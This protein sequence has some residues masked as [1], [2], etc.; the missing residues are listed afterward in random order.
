[1]KKTVDTLSKA[2]RN[3]GIEALRMVSMLMV[4]M[5]HIMGHGGILSAAVPGTLRYAAVWLW[6]TAAYCAVDCFA[7]ISGYVGAADRKGDI[8]PGFL[9]LWLRAAFYGLAVTAAFSLFYPDE[10]SVKD[11]IAA[12]LPVGHNQYWYLTAYFALMLFRP[13]LNHVL[14]TM[15]SQSLGRMAVGIFIGFSVFPL[16]VGQD[17]FRMGTGYHSLWFLCL[18]LLG[19]WMKRAELARRGRTGWCLLTYALLTL[20]TWGWK[21]G[22]EFAGQE[23][24]LVMSY[25]SP[26]VLLSGGALVLAFARMRLPRRLERTVLFLAPSAFS[27]Y[28]LHDQTLV[29]KYLIADRM[30][31]L[32]EGRTWRLLVLIPVAALTIYLLCTAVDLIRRLA[33]TPFERKLKRGIKQLNFLQWF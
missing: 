31:V 18:Y 2:E 32:G 7:L 21:L 24:G 16:L 20:L 25:L 4:V 29:R 19:G 28:L 12:A 17:L 33:F 15:D 8:W 6:E 3:T 5:L 10:V 27:V 26:P 11:W 1:M 14:V 30:T 23:T 13:A 9:I 22:L